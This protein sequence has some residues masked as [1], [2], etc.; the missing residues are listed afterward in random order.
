MSRSVY[1]IPPNA[2]VLF[3]P[4]SVGQPRD[5]V[6]LASYAILDEEARVFEHFRVD[7]DINKVQ[8]QLRQANYDAGLGTRL[9]Q[10]R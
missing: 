9:E 5:G 4:G 1:R 7:F 2:Q 10:G 8:R 6:P 3:N